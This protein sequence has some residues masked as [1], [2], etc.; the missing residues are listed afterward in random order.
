[1]RIELNDYIKMLVCCM[2]QNVHTVDFLPQAWGKTFTVSKIEK[3]EFERT[4][5]SL[6]AH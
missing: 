1:M 3:F 5:I 4:V 2:G 6:A